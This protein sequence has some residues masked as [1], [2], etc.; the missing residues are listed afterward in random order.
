MAMKNKSFFRLCVVVFLGV[1]FSSP[2]YAQNQNEKILIVYFSWSGNTR[3]IARQ[4]QGKTGGDM[5]EIVPAVSYPTDSDEAH[6]VA[7]RER[8]SGARPALKTHVRNMRQYDTVILGFPVWLGTLPA[9]V[10]TFLEEYDFSGKHIVPFRS[11]GNHDADSSDA[12]IKKLCPDS[13]IADALSVHRRGGSSL[14]NDISAWLRKAGI[15]EK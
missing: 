5:F 10:V 15:G 9:P 8:D 11:Y 13:V 2:L 3:E 1:L 12:A 6:D 14:R 7:R 4:I